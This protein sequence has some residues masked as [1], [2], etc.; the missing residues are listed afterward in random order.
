MYIEFVAIITSRI[1]YL[2]FRPHRFVLGFGYGFDAS[3]EAMTGV[4]LLI[5][6]MFLEIAFEAVV[7]AF[8]LSI[9]RRHGIDLNKFW[10][11]WRVNAL[12]FWGNIV[13]QGV[14][15][16]SD[17]CWAF[18]L[19]PNAVF[20]TSPMDPCS[21]SGGGFEIY[22]RFCNKTNSNLT[23]TASVE[24]AKIEFS[25]IFDAL[26]GDSETVLVSVGVVILVPV[27]FVVVRSQLEVKEAIRVKDEAELQK[28]E[29]LEQ[30]KR[31][32]DELALHELNEEQAEIV[33][34]GAA[35]LEAAVPAKFKIASNNI[36]FEALLGSGSFGDCYKGHFYNVAVAVKQMRVVSH[37]GVL[38]AALADAVN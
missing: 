28:L 33:H 19:I 12:A 38:L 29:L 31:I 24:Q 25:G 8:A 5:T 13:F 10:A 37:I 6:S 3:D 34:A 7:D 26:E 16:I 9:E 11:M 32:Q 18:K 23:K 30:N 20:C 4:P 1:M 22:D 35:S 27:V 14:V 15:A 36:T 17:T 2:M 21:C